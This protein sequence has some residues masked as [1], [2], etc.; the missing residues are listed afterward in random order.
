[1]YIINYIDKIHFN[2]QHVNSYNVG[3]IVKKMCFNSGVHCLLVVAP[4]ICEPQSSLFL[5]SSANNL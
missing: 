2:H 3:V 5:N 4:Q 1:M